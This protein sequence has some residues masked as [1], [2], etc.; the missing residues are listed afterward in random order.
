MKGGNKDDN[1]Y[2]VIGNDR[3]SEKGKRYAWEGSINAELD[4]REASDSLFGEDGN[5]K[6]IVGK[7]K[8]CLKV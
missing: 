6:R 2:G 5:D 3:F 1:I 4:G 7:A 8:D